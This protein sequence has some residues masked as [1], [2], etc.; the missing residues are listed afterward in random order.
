MNKIQKAKDERFLATMK[1]Y[2]GLM[3]LQA[4]GG[5]VD[6]AALE[7]ALREYRWEKNRKYHRDR[8]RT[9][10]AQAQET[11]THA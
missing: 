6:P 1:L 3:E 2:H 4:S 9:M 7:T 5:E 8:K 10:R 11:P